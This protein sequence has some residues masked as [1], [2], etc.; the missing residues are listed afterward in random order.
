LWLRGD[1]SGLLTAIAFTGILQ[2]ALVSTFVWD[3]LISTGFRV[4]LWAT[5]GCIWLVTAIASVRRT[6]F[7]LGSPHDESVDALFREAQSEYLKGNWFQAEALLER[8]LR[9]NSEDVDARL[10][11]VGLYRQIKRFGEATGQL[12][13]AE[14]DDITGKWQLEIKRERERL[15]RWESDA[16]DSKTTG[17][18]V[19]SAGNP[20]IR[21]TEIP[22]AA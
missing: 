8:V 1:L 6:P 15:V 22:D 2:A 4:C 3:E 12:D 21:P 20:G 10:M 11:L 19:Q 9:H 5:L 17:S 16:S 7:R 13:L 18:P 14:R